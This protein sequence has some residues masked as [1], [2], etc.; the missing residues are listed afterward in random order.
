MKFPKNPKIGE[1]FKA[2]T[3]SKYSYKWNGDAWDIVSIINAEDR[4]IEPDGTS[5]GII[6]KLVND[7]YNE[8]PIGKIDGENKIFILKLNP[9]KGSEKIYI[10]GMLQTSGSDYQ[11]ID[12]SIYLEHPLEDNDK[13]ICSYSE[14]KILEISNEIP[15]GLIDGKNKTFILR[16][17]PIEFSEFIYLNGILLKKGEEYDYVISNN[18]FILKDSPF[19]G[20]RL[21][22]SYQSIL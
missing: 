19:S 15:T 5:A 22:C 11:I 20:E 2:N 14:L 18:V 4:G 12:N 1:L 13:I 16:K 6:K 8:T 9:I 17:I 21:I 10:N 3:S 7:I